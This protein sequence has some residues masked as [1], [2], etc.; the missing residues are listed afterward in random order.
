MRRVF[1]FALLVAAFHVAAQAQ[2]PHFTY[3]GQLSQNG[4][5]VNGTRNLSFQLVSA[6]SG[7]V[8]LGSPINAPAWPV[9]DG[10]FTIELRF[11]NAPLSFPLWIEVRV[12]GIPVLPRQQIAA[13]PIAQS[14]QWGLEGPPGEQGPQGGFG[15]PGEPGLL[16][17]R[18][19]ASNQVIG[20]LSNFSAG[21]RDRGISDWRRI[22]TDFMVGNLA[23]EQRRVAC[24]PGEVVLGGGV[25]QL[26]RGSDFGFEVRVIESFPT[27][28]D[29]LWAWQLAVYNTGAPASL[30]GFAT[31]AQP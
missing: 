3:Q 8:W 17:N 22:S 12:D 23:V 11:S 26:Q 18:S 31:C 30:R 16:P 25:E 9:I 7:G 27:F 24:Q 6:A 15:P 28:V 4:Q 13:A 2:T 5:P 20:S 14:A 19:C 10:L 1:I 21:C 29:G